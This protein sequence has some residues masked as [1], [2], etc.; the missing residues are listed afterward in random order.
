MPRFIERI[1]T[2]TANLNTGGTAPINTYE[3]FTG[4]SRVVLRDRRGTA[5]AEIPD[6]D[7]KGFGGGSDPLAIYR[8]TGAK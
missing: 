5:E 1:F 6:V 7:E 8:P 4:D 2:R 3:G